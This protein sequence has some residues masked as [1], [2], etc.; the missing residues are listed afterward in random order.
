VRDEIELSE[1]TISRIA[2]AVAQKLAELSPRL[3]PTATPVVRD[4][5]YMMT[6]DEVAAFLRI[7]K[8]SLYNMRTRGAGPHALKVGKHLRYRRS[9]IERWLDEQQES[10]WG[11]GIR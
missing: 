2:E 1:A 6:A 3:E 5:E 10:G 11:S 9:D 8:Q 4:P 7:P